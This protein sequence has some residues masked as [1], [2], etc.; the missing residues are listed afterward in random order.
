MARR[1]LVALFITCIAASSVLFVLHL[2]CCAERVIPGEMCGVCSFVHSGRKAFE[3]L[4]ADAMSAFDISVFCFI[5]LI[6]VLGA[7]FIGR[8]SLITLKMRM[9]K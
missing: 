6:V 9:D 5:A 3:G 7:C 8:S 2:S 1:A 4:S